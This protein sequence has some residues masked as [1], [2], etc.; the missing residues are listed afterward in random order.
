MVSSSVNLAVCRSDYKLLFPRLLS[1]PT[2]NI[3]F[4]LTS[5]V[6]SLFS[7][8]SLILIFIRIYNSSWHFTVLWNNSMHSKEDVSS[9]FYNVFSSLQK[10]RVLINMFTF[11]DRLKQRNLLS[12][13]FSS[14]CLHMSSDQ[15]WVKALISYLFQLLDILIDIKIF[16]FNSFKCLMRWVRKVPGSIH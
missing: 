6:F 4:N 16:M 8:V 14:C 9:S 15:D 10:S 5:S 1:L 13:M 3:W 11:C 2:S 12:W 7:E